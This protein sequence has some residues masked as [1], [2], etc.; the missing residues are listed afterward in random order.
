[1]I[2]SGSALPEELR[3]IRDH[4]P[5][6]LVDVYPTLLGIAGIDVPEFLPGENLLS[7]SVRE[8]NFCG[9]HEREGEAAFMWRTREHKL[10][11][12]FPRKEAA[13]K[14]TSEDIIGGEF[15]DLLEDP[16]EWND[17]YGTPDVMALQTEM[18]G[19]LMKHLGKLGRRSPNDISL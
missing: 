6:E 15:Y 16:R 5:A 9:L 11:L 4:R 19:A 13:D 7:S 18:T 8:A 1:M 12:R 17:V 3:A 2:L 10:I 14:Y